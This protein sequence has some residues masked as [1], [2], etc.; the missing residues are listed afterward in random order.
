MA[1]SLSCSCNGRVGFIDWL[2]ES[3]YFLPTAAP[4]Y[5]DEQSC[6]GGGK[7]AEKQVRNADP[8]NRSAGI[9]PRKLIREGAGIPRAEH[10]P[11]DASR[12]AQDEG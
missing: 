2:D 1:N 5:R 10:Y 4:I 12:N 9:L 3:T 11:A 8:V 7:K 6:S